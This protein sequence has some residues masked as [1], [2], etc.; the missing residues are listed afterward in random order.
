MQTSVL[1][2]MGLWDLGWVESKDSV[3]CRPLG[4]SQR[5]SGVVG[6]GTLGVLP[7]LAAHVTFRMTGVGVEVGGF[8]PA[9]LQATGFLKRIG[10]CHLHCPLQ[11]SSPSVPPTPEQLSVSGSL[12]W[13]LPRAV[14]S[15]TFGMSLK[16]AVTSRIHEIQMT[17]FW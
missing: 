15:F 3:S 1:G 7:G 14:T 4:C 11:K 10:S 17:C 8:S 13:S 2:P 12:Q 5:E 9:S 6:L 16:L